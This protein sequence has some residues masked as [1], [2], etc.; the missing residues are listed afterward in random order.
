[1]IP[2]RRPDPAPSVPSADGSIRPHCRSFSQNKPA[3][4]LS[5]PNQ[6]LAGEGITWRYLGTGP[7]T[8]SV[9]AFCI[10][11][12]RS[13]N[14]EDV[15]PSLLSYRLAWLDRPAPRRRILRLCGTACTRQT[16]RRWLAG[17]SRAMQPARYPIRGS[18]SIVHGRSS[19][20]L[21]AGEHRRATSLRH[22]GWQRPGAQARKPIHTSS[23]RPLKCDRD[24]EPMSTGM[25]GSPWMQSAGP[26]RPAAPRC[27]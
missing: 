18:V 9:A 7:G 21:S 8:A 12:L 2:G 11:S 19:S 27:N 23:I 3:R 4:I 10:A 13:H 24:H 1:M 14:I 26:S 15:R 17:F 22:A 5:P 16:P 25:S 20:T 6:K